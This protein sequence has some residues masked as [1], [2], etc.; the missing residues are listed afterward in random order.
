[1]DKYCF[2]Y[3]KIDGKPAEIKGPGSYEDHRQHMTD[4][5]NA[6][7]IIP[8]RGKKPKSVVSDATI[9][10]STKGI[11]KRREFKPRKQLGD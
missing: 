2:T 5:V 4:L 9:Y 3:G 8:G 1:M 7:G 10:H 6:N 11:V